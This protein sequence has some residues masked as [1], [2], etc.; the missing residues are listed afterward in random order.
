MPVYPGRY[1]SE[2]GP[3]R[4]HTFDEEIAFLRG[5]NRSTG[6]TVGLYPE[7]K[8]PAWHR[9]QGTDLTE[10]VLATLDRHG[11][12]SADDNVWLQCFDADELTRIRRGLDCQ[13][14][15][16]QLIADD[17]WQ[18]STTDYKTLRSANG[19]AERRRVVNAFG[20]WI[21]QLFEVTDG[22]GLEASPFARRL[23]DCGLPIHP[24]TLRTD[25]LPD[26]AT[27][28][29]TLVRFLATTLGAA[30]VFADQPD[31]VLRVLS[32]IG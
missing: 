29:D 6:R 28:F 23:L 3:F 18:E 26:A 17:D 11:Y 14:K 1:P 20:P 12:R 4:L 16:V 22:G 27:D 7:I 9:L 13:L 21:P 5:L 2:P 19:L 8:R 24:Y 30:A 10:L 15:L 25:D 31:R 32:D